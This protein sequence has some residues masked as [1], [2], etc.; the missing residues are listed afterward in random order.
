MKKITKK[1]IFNDLM[2]WLKI[3]HQNKYNQYQYLT[4]MEKKDFAIKLLKYYISLFPDFIYI[5]PVKLLDLLGVKYREY[6]NS[7]KQVNALIAILDVNKSDVVIIE[8]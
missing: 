7:Y 8:E 3:R 4:D 1:T 6:D 5:L 2:S